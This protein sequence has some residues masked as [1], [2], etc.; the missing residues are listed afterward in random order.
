[1]NW[2]SLHTIANFIIY[3]LI[4]LLVSLI[5]YNLFYLYKRYTTSTIPKNSINV[6]PKYNDNIPNV[7][8]ND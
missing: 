8:I 1:M 2:K 4:S 6:S 7:L 3:S 5:F